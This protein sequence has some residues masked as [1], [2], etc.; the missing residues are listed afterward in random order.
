M[1]RPSSAADVVA[2]HVTLAVDCTERMYLN[3]YRP[4]LQHVVT[5]DGREEASVPMRQPQTEAISSVS[6]WRPGQAAL[7]VGPAPLWLDELFGSVT[8]FAARSSE[9]FSVM[10]PTLCQFCPPS[11]VS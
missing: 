9:C 6:G 3:V 1:T 8:G 10:D 7:A 5:G 11:A 2:R 4:R